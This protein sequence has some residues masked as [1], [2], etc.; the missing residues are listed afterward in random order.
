MEFVELGEV[1]VGFVKGLT[2]DLFPL[3]LQIINRHIEE[4][5]LPEVMQLSQGVLIAEDY[6]AVAAGVM[7]IGARRPSG[8]HHLGALRLHLD[9]MTNLI[10]VSGEHSEKVSHPAQPLSS[11]AGRLQVS[12]ISSMVILPP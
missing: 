8:I 4:V 5:F 2:H 7:L 1:T 3:S 12:L 6:G 11:F 10:V 9:C